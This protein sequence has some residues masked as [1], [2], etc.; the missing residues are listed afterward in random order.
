M[1]LNK[2]YEK[3]YYQNWRKPF[4]K[5]ELIVFGIVE[6]LRGRRGISQEWDHVDDI[7]EEILESLL[8][9]TEKNLI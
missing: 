5:A 8:K 6:N 4:T 3:Y 7:Q 2:K 9:I 1:T